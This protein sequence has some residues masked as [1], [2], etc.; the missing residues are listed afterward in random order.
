MWVGLNPVAGV[1]KGKEDTQRRR[2]TWRQRW[3]DLSINQGT[4][5]V[6]ESWRR[7]G[8]VSPRRSQACQHPNLSILVSRTVRECISVVLS[9][10]IYGHL[11]QQPQETNIYSLNPASTSSKVCDLEQVSGRQWKEMSWKKSVAEFKSLQSCWRAL[12]VPMCCV[13]TGDGAKIGK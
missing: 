6:T 12:V 2:A 11:L 13:A 5:S 10:P 1:L 3:S 9:H 7:Q 4:L 8:T